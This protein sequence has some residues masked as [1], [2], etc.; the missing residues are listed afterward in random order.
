MKRN[1]LAVLLALSLVGLF[2]SPG[3]AQVLGYNMDRAGQGFGHDLAAEPSAARVASD[4]LIARPIGL[5]LT[6]AGTA[7]FLIT[8]PFSIPSHSVK[9][10]AQGLIVKPG[11][12][13]FKRPLG[14][15]VP[16]FEER[17]LFPQ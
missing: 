11:G 10:A 15:S 4:A 13:T 9:T 6:V 1:M 14:H 8:L 16:R 12:Y 17:T 2:G 5:A 3:L 7:T